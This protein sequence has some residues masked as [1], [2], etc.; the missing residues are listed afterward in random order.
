MTH[1]S[2]NDEASLESLVA[3]VADEFLARQK[4]GERPAVEEYAAR[5]PQAAEVL[6]RVLASLQLL[7]LS[8]SAGAAGGGAAEGT[9]GGT[10]GD[11]RILREVGRGGMRIVY[12]AEQLSLERRVAL[13]VLPFAAALDPRQLQRFQNEARAAAHLHHSNIVPVHAVGC[14]RG[15][16][17]YAMQFIDGQTMAAV[18]RELRQRAGFEGPAPPYGPGSAG[19]GTDNLVSDSWLAAPAAAPG[20]NTAPAAGLSTAGAAPQ[21]AFFTTVARMGLQAAEALEYAHAEGVIHRDIK[22]ANLLV[23]WRAGGVNSP[24]LWI[25]DFGLARFRNEAGLTLTGDLLGT[26]RYMSPEQALGPRQRVDH[27]TDV[28]SLGATLYELLTLEPVHR[29]SDRQELLGQIAWEAP[30]PPRRLNPAV[31]PDLET[32]ILKALDKDPEGRYATAQEMADDLRRFLEDKPI[33][34]KRPTAAQRLRK[35]ARRHKALVAAAAV[36]LVITAVAGVLTA[37]LVWREKLRADH[38]RD[39]AREAAAA[40]Q[41]ARQ[42]EAKERRR[43]EAREG[44]ARQ[45][46][47]IYAQLAEKVLANRPHMEAEERQLLERVLD[48]YKELTSEPTTEPGI[49]LETGRAYRRMGDIQQKLGRP[50]EAEKAYGQALQVLE[51]LAALV[52]AEPSYRYE[53]AGSLNNLAGLLLDT[54]RPRAAEGP[55]RRAVALYEK[56]ADGTADGA[57]PEPRDGPPDEREEI[58]RAKRFRFDLA[59]SHA[60]LGRMLATTGRTDEAARA[61]ERALALQEKLAAGNP[62]APRYRHALAVT[63]YHYAELF[64]GGG[65]MAKAASAYERAR[66]IAQKLADDAPAVAVYR[67][68]LADSH[69]HLGT[70]FAE[71]GRF[72]EAEEA[73]RQAIRLQQKLGADFPKVPGYRADLAHSQNDLAVIFQMAGRDADAERQF[74]ETQALLEKLV[75]G[76]PAVPAYQHQL[77]CT[78]FNLG[79]LLERTDRPAEA[80]PALRRAQALYEKL[81]AGCAVDVRFD[82]A[83]TLNGLAVALSRA[84]P[85]E[86]ALAVQRQAVAVYET[87]VAEFPK[88][89]D[90]QSHLAGALAN[91]AFLHGIQGKWA[92]A[93]PLFD[94]AIEHQQATLTQKPGHVPYRRA[95]RHHY[96]RLA[97]V[98]ERLGKSEEAARARAQAEAVQVQRP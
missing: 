12:E 90:Y 4:Q 73:C 46:A 16:H 31:P 11:F 13:K 78:A 10:L 5:H 85:P 56:L 49:R 57:T 45:A 18:I 97:E 47:E 21:P 41:E 60:N 51:P 25:T 87:L 7:D 61:Y 28:Y 32:I 9:V 54:S 66:A 24:T 29:G 15:M 44:F 59:F 93:G 26:L 79:S 53:L 74:R 17:F 65:Q 76:H 94:R 58:A 3:R 91:V 81:A 96:R 42:A 80:I 36:V 8:A 86:E 1:A 52:P 14:A 43:A 48:F 92:E 84:G 77:A 88:V 50:A 40:E 33:R 69:A 82:Q 19:V 67:Q 64:L 71:T 95:L 38:E 35:W 30:R 27:R 23:E 83:G 55:L 75:E 37:F 34:A 62:A 89:P 22:P 20:A 2:A 70:V 6:R 68:V 63:Y 98:L 39:R 72:D